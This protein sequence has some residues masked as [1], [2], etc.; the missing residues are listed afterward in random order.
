[1]ACLLAALRDRGLAACMLFRSIWTE[2]CQAYCPANDDRK[3]VEDCLQFLNA[4]KVRKHLGTPTLQPVKWNLAFSLQVVLGLTPNNAT[5][6]FCG[7]PHRAAWSCPMK[8]SQMQQANCWSRHQLT[9]GA[10]N[11]KLM[12][13]VNS[14]RRGEKKR[15]KVSLAFAEKMWQIFHGGNLHPQLCY[16]T[17]RCMVLTHMA[18]FER[19]IN[20]LSNGV[21]FIAKKHCSN[22]EIIYQTHIF[23]HFVYFTSN[24]SKMCNNIVFPWKLLVWSGN[25]LKT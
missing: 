7:T 16:S 9:T 8:I 2:S 1:M 17:H 3:S 6:W 20:R 10:G 11:Q 19:E 21:R 4:D 13:R 22:T 12:T 25:E 18:L 24:T 14:N 23:L 5:A 15:K